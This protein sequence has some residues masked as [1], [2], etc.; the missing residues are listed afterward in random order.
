MYGLPA[1][2]NQ[3]NDDA[4]RDLEGVIEGVLVILGVNEGVTD[5]EDVT[6]GVTDGDG[7]K[8]HGSSTTPV[9]LTEF[10]IIPT[11]FP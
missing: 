6:L 1:E 11:T 9:E 2:P 3:A 7:H 8:V 5:G 10:L 4:G